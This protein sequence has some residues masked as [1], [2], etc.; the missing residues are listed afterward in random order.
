[1]V[2]RVERWGEELEKIRFL[3]KEMERIEGVRQ[4]G[5]RPKMHT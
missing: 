2:R 5:M 1:V 4:I 3:V